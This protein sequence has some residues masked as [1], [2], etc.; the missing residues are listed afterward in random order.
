MITLVGVGHVFGLDEHVK[1]IVHERTPGVV[2]LELDQERFEALKERS[3]ERDPNPI[4]YILEKFQARIAHSYGATPGSEMLAAAD[5]AR[6][7]G[8]KLALIDQDIRT[9]MVRLWKLLPIKEKVILFVNGFSS[10]F[11]S[12]KRIAAEVE[13][14]RTDDSYMDEFTKDAPTFKQVLIDERNRHMADALLQMS[15]QTAGIV[16]IVGDGHVPGIA[17]ILAGSGAQVEVI[18][19]RDIAKTE[20]S[21]RFASFD[22]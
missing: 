1:R 21:N 13:R 14:L 6:E 4:F 22:F 5:S 16:A 9:T 17:S 3:D 2:C 11:A 20:E 12:K 15:K 8:A 18:R 7:V 10:L 19:L